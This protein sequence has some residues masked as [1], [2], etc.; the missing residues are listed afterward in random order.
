MEKM[1]TP[2]KNISIYHCITFLLLVATWY[3]FSL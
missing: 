2:E 1:Q 3:V